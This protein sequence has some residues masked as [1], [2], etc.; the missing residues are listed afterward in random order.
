[1]YLLICCVFMFIIGIFLLLC[2][3]KFRSI[4]NDLC[5]SKHG[6][7]NQN[8]LLHNY[9]RIY[10]VVYYNIIVL[11]TN[12]ACTIFYIVT[13]RPLKFEKNDI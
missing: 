2:V 12:L 6:K 13:T 10:S 11:D 8:I 5:I 7:P 3:P 9:Y 4:K 1:M